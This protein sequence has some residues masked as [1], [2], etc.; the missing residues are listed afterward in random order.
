MPS[1]QP[2]PPSTGVVGEHHLTYAQIA[3]RLAI[4]TDA[5][6]LLVRR[7]GW[8]RITPNRLGAPAI[9]IIPDEALAAEDWRDRPTP[10][11]VTDPDPASPEVTTDHDR[12][13]P[14]G[15]AGI[16][17]VLAALRE[18]HASEIERL[19]GAL[20]QAEGRANAE[21]ARADLLL[22]QSDGLRDRLMAVEAKLAVSQGA[23]Q[24]AKE[25]L[26]SANERLQVTTDRLS[27]T[28]ERLTD[29]EHRLAEAEQVKEAARKRAHELAN[30]MMTLEAAAEEGKETKERLTGLDRLLA[31]A[32]R[33][34]AEAEQGRATAQERLDAQD[35]AEVTRRGRGRLARLRAAWRGE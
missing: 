7:R 20:G 14:G 1:D 33:R 6:R 3:A 26:Q 4:S 9:I 30:R 21:R 13:T 18:A 16:E 25:R 24:D 5:A 27:E 12:S 23:T 32:E 17:I 8:R 2:S 22:H 15:A 11:V 35:R 29:A 34:L 10:G 31:D 19:T 28:T